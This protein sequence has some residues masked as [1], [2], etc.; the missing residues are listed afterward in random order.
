MESGVI[1]TKKRHTGHI[2]FL[3]FRVQIIIAIETLETK[4][5]GIHEAATK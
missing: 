1:F 5:T 2:K 4:Q 3:P